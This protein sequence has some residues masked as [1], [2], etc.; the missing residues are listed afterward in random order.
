MNLAIGKVFILGMGISTMAF[1]ELKTDNSAKS[2]LASNILTIIFALALNWS[3]MTLLWGYWLQ[4]VIIGI[5]TVP[6]ILMAQ[7]PKVE[8]NV[9]KSFKASNVSEFATKIFMAGFFCL[10]YGIFHFSYFMFLAFFS[11]SG[12]FGRAVTQPDWIGVSLIGVIFFANHLYSLFSNYLNDGKRITNTIDQVF[13][14]PYTRIIPMH[15]TIMAAGFLT[16]LAMFFGAVTGSSFVQLLFEKAIIV[17][18]LG[19]KTFLDLMGHGWL[20]KKD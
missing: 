18:F 4:S 13:M 9:S 3:V 11:F 2:L 8:W 1:V 16:P 17:F 7:M 14:G 5:F 12:F 20:H 15:L 10:H 19:L 6:K